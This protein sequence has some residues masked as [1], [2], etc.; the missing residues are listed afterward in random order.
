MPDT[1]LPS[2]PPP[3]ASSSVGPPSPESQPGTPGPPGL[4]SQPRLSRNILVTGA[5]GYIGGR[6][7]PRLVAAG[8]RVKVFVR[9]PQKLGAVPWREDVEIIRGDLDDAAA[10]EQACQGIDV[11]YYLVHSMGGSSD[12]EK[13]EAAMAHTVAD[14][15]GKAGVARIVYLGGLHPQNVELSPHMRSRAAV[16]QILLEAKVDAMVLQAGVVIGS[17]SAS[18]EMIRHLADVLPVMPAP[19]WV[20]NRIEPIAI[21]DVLYYL[22]AAASV[23]GRVNKSFDIGSREVMPY[24]QLMKIYA[25]E[26]GLGN[27]LVFPFPLPV[28]RLAGYWVALVTPIPLSMSRPLVQSLQHDAVGGERGIDDYIRQPPGGPTGFRSAVRLALEKEKTGDVVTSWAGAGGF[29]PE[30][31]PLPS[32]PDWAGHTVYTDDRSRHYEVDPARMWKV[33]EGIGGR[34]GWYSLPLAWSIRGWMDKLVGGTGLTR[35]RRNPD[36]LSVGDS[37][38][39]WRVEKIDRGQLLLLR[40]EMRAP[41]RAWLEFSVQPDG[42]GSLYRQRAIFFPKGLSGRLYWLAVLPFHAFI[43]PAMSRNIAAEAQQRARERAPERGDD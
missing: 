3:P 20:R 13:R 6:L 28:P 35:G 16:G 23:P 14:A 15:C 26:A 41:G 27:R 2:E 33:I 11:V 38:D 17:G 31:D 29:G 18:F 9:S 42:T 19:R 4:E 24:A 30:A 10:L 1:A 40:A 21:R 34:S 7:V 36:R 5:T 39:W 22:V 43:F 8:H 37:L 25:L 32:D 12:F